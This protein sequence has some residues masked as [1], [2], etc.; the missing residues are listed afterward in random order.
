MDSLSGMLSQDRLIDWWPAFADVDRLW[1]E[2]R[3]QESDEL[4]QRAELE[5]PGSPVLKL[6]RAHQLLEV[7]ARQGSMRETETV[8]QLVRQATRAAATNAYVHLEAAMIFLEL[9]DFET[10]ARHVVA[11]EPLYDQ[12]VDGPSRARLAFVL[13]RLAEIKGRHDL[14]E[15]LLAEAVAEAPTDEN[16]LAELKR[17]RESRRSSTTKM[18]WPASAQSAPSSTTR[19]PR[20]SST[21][22]RP[23]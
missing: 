8:I 22:T 7:N 17:F 11:T 23:S 2:G 13:G 15:Q 10:A 19:Q 5:H 12:F 9:G 20:R 18:S 1:R 21:R 6:V 16:Y 4:L 14:A 3:L